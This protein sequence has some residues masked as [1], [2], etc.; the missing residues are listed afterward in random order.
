MMIKSKTRMANEYI[1]RTGKTPE[2]HYTSDSMVKDLLKLIPFETGDNVLDPCSGRNKVWFKNFYVNT[3]NFEL[4]IEEGKNFF[5]WNIPVDWII[6][7]PPFSQGVMFVEHALSF[8]RKGVGFLGNHNFI[9]SL[10]LPRRMESYKA[11]HFAISNIHIVEDK[12]WFGRYYFVVF[13]HHWMENAKISWGSKI[14][15]DGPVNTQELTGASD[16]WEL[17]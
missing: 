1:A 7:N 4:E 8:C 11:R 9:N 12:R 14:Y 5:N 16:D 10:F 13:K 3:N 2:S 15:K 6:G 17:F